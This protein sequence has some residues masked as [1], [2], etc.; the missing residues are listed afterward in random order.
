[1][2]NVMN[3][4]VAVPKLVECA[5]RAQPQ[6]QMRARLQPELK[7]HLDVCADCQERWDAEC[8]LTAGLRLMRIQAS[9]GRAP[10]A[11]RSAVMQGFAV[12]EFVARRRK[13]ASH[14][15]LW[16]VAAAA[17]LLISAVAARDRLLPVPSAPVYL[18]DDQN[19]PQQEGFIAVA[20]A[21]PLA[22][23]ELVRVIHMELQPAELA[24]L[25]VNVDPSWTT[26]LPADVLVGQDGFPRAVRV[27][28]ENS[29]AGDY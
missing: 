10:L 12:Q 29:G 25:G 11:V 19:E 26:E 14:R 15:W 24:S 2:K 6:E 21:P 22:P 13:S 3:C 5:R 17:V 8:S 1:M 7:R 9:A 23:G 20:Y 27:S 4:R 16:S 28:D 18:A